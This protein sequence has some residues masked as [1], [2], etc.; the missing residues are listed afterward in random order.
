MEQKKLTRRQVEYLS[1]E[2]RRV[3]VRTTTPLLNNLR[4]AG[5]LRKSARHT[6]ASA[7]G[8]REYDLPLAVSQQMPEELRKDTGGLSVA[9]MEALRDHLRSGRLNDPTDNRLAL[10]EQQLPVRKALDSLL[11]KWLADYRAREAARHGRSQVARNKAWA[12]QVRS[13]LVSHGFGPALAHETDTD[14]H[15]LKLAKAITSAQHDLDYVRFLDDADLSQ[16]LDEQEKT[17]TRPGTIGDQSRSEIINAVRAEFVR[18][19]GGK[20]AAA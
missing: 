14:E 10:I 20:P 2:L 15:L 1:G 13:L 18:R 9:G 6:V 5:Y 4:S 17:A 19:A 8:Y 12:G 11:D 3:H 7:L 16:L